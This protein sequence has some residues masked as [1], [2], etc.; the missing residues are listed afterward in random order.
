MNAAKLYASLGRG[1][2]PMIRH[3]RWVLAHG[4]SMGLANDNPTYRYWIRLGKASGKWSAR[5]GKPR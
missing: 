1:S 3:S 5:W 4:S 2:A